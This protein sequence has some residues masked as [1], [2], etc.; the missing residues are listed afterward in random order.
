MRTFKQDGRATVYQTA[1]SYPLPSGMRRRATAASGSERD[2]GPPRR[3]TT[4]GLELSYD[5]EGSIRN[6]ATHIA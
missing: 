4:Q 2:C 3:T 1:Q 6:D 5:R